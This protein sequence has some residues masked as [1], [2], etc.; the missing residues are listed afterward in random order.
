MKGEKS[1]SALASFFHSSPFLA[2]LFSTT[3]ENVTSST[4]TVEEVTG[5]H[6]F[7]IERY[8]RVKKLNPKRQFIKSATFRVGGYDWY[9]QFYPNGDGRAKDGHTSLFVNF[10]STSGNVKAHMTVDFLDQ[11]GKQLS[12]NLSREAAVTF[13][14]NHKSWGRSS[15]VRTSALESADLKND[16]LVIE[17]TV[18]VLKESVLKSSVL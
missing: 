8:S 10:N 16:C 6:L 11:N 13:N 4:M 14:C 12:D 1:N 17:C 2:K 15:F 7:K 5:S 3:V 18:R 9:V